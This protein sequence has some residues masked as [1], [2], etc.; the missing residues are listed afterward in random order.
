MQ[1]TAAIKITLTIH[2]LLVDKAL[3]LLAQLKAPFVLMQPART[4][5]LKVKRGFSLPHKKMRI[6]DELAHIIQFYVPPSME[7]LCFQVIIHNLDL[8]LPGR[9]SIYSETVNLYYA[10]DQ[11]SWEGMQNLDLTSLVD[12]KEEKTS[13]KPLLSTQM[14]GI[15]LICNRDSSANICETL[16]SHGYPAPVICYGQ[17]TG[18]RERMGLLRI[19]NSP[20]KEIATLAV[21]YKDLPTILSLLYDL[22]QLHLPGKGFLLSYPIR[23]AK[24]NTRT[25]LEATAQLAS[26]DQVISAIDAIKGDVEWRRK[27]TSDYISPNHHHVPQNLT[28][29]VF[30]GER[31]LTQTVPAK[32]IALGARGATTSRK[33]LYCFCSEVAHAHEHHTSHE[34]EACSITVPSD[35]GSELLKQVLE[36]N[37]LSHHVILETSGVIH[38]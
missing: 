14:Q 9:G 2:H 23:Y 28:N 5:M 10:P 18:M 22:A 25:H 8:L 36:E 32:A 17:G 27:T 6:V 4:S 13:I 1:A 37:L 19:T 3:A 29:F 30:I 33:T 20:E 16:L 38:F 12:P 21:Y 26:L 31:G 15:S 35:V 7:I 34:R 24:M 11:L